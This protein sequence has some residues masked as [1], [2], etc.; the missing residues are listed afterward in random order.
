MSVNSPLN[1]QFRR[2]FAERA[3][4]TKSGFALC[5]LAGQA[6]VT[7]C[8]AST[9]RAG[10][11][12]KSNHPST[13]TL[14]LCSW[15]GPSRVRL[16]SRKR[17]AHPVGC[18]GN[19]QGQVVLSH[20]AVAPLMVACG[21]QGAERAWEFSNSRSRLLPLQR[22]Q[23]A[24]ISTMTP[25]AGLPARQPV[26]SSRA[27]LAAARLPVRSSVARQ[28]CS[29]TISTFRAASTAKPTPQPLRHSIVIA[30]S[31]PH[32]P[33]ALFYCQHQHRGGRQHLV[34]PGRG[35]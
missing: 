27:R 16:F 35:A 22:L 24:T 20:R 34:N 17:H 18:I 9:V 8:A 10:L 7:V 1:L 13:P 32:A 29:V 14:T 5:A 12:P 26:R 31:G 2:H 25:N 6:V 30:P 23:V 33:V 15:P 21:Q 4:H 28:A 3:A 11:K 19:L